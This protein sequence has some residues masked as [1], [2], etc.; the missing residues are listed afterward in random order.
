[1]TSDSYSTTC[2]VCVVCRCVCVT[3]SQRQTAGQEK[4]VGQLKL[5]ANPKLCKI[6]FL[7]GHRLGLRQAG[8]PK[9]LSAQAD[10]APT[11]S[12][13]FLRHPPTSAGVPRSWVSLSVGGIV[14]VT[15]TSA[16]ILPSGARCLNSSRLCAPPPQGAT[17]VVGVI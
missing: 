14:V 3:R 11:S 2:V 8:G 5:P 13:P 12:S 16:G 1:M 6:V 10:A 15:T 4:Q 17:V 9:L 7:P